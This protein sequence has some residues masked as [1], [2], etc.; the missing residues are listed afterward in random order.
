M[1]FLAKCVVAL[2]LVKSLWRQKINTFASVVLII[3]YLE[4]VM[5]TEQ[6][7]NIPSPHLQISGGKVHTTRLPYIE[8]LWY[9]ASD[10]LQV[11][12]WVAES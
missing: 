1:P 7:L 6:Q 8:L 9:Y 11:W 5:N 12:L 2:L 3:F 4:T 10:L